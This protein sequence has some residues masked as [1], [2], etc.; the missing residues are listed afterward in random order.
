MS[1]KHAE[2]VEIIGKKL[3]L[4]GRSACGRTDG[5]VVGGEAV[6]VISCKH[7]LRVLAG[8]AKAKRPRG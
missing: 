2:A 6:Q 1:R 5:K 7:C 3:V 4:T 8:E